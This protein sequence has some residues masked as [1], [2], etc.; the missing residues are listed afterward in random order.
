MVLK[1]RKKRATSERTADGIHG[2][3]A[4]SIPSSTSV[5]R[6]FQNSRYAWKVKRAARR[7]TYLEFRRTQRKG[8][9]EAVFKNL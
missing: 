1:L 6:G 9:A 2:G 5:L 3:P 7:Y 8:D 4:S